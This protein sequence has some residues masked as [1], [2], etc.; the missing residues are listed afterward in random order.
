MKLYQDINEVKD[1]LLDNSKILSLPINNKVKELLLNAN[2]D[3]LCSNAE[4]H[5]AKIHSHYTYVRDF[6][7]QAGISERGTVHDLSKW[8]AEELFESIYFYEGTRSPIDKANEIL[9]WSPAFTHHIRHNEHQLENSIYIN[10]GMI[11][12]IKK[13]FEAS[14]E[15][16]CDFCG[17]AKAY[18]GEKFTFKGEI[19]WW[20]NRKKILEEANTIHPLTSM[21]ITKSLEQCAEIERILTY[22]EFQK[23]WEEINKS[24][25]LVLGNDILENAV[26]I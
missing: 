20:N 26:E 11:K 3:V 23:V 25:K 8:S 13:E 7:Q 6:C 12:P 1:I 4:L 15:V 24:N 18:L 9:G 21:F 10:G 5:F 22:T 16:V 14:I 2:K 19:Q 17:A